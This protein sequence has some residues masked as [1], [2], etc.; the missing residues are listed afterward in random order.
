MILEVFLKLVLCQPST[1]TFPFSSD[2]LHIRYLRKLRFSQW[3]TSLDSSLDLSCA[4]ILV[5]EQ[6]IFTQQF[7]F[8][9]QHTRYMTVSFRNPRVSKG[10]LTSWFFSVHAC[11][12]PCIYVPMWVLKEARS[13]H[14]DVR[15]VGN[16]VFI[17]ARLK[18]GCSLSKDAMEK[19]Y[20]LG[21]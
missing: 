20:L 13:Q 5:Q 11:T 14:P 9:P 4:W 3:L 2:L 17:G 21:S 1:I 18:S 8:R 12:C 7:V 19:R 16:A 10:A 15:K 6:R